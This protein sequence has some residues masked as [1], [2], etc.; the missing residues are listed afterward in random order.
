MKKVIFEEGVEELEKSAVR[1]FP[2]ITGSLIYSHIKEV[3]FP[4][5]VNKINKYAKQN[6]LDAE[7]KIMCGTNVLAS[8]MPKFRM[9]EAGI[10][11]IK[12]IKDVCLLGAGWREYEN[13]P[14][15]Y[16]KYFW[17]KV[18][19][20]ELIHSVRDSYTEEKLKKLGFENVV[21]TSCPTMWRLTPEHCGQI[22]TKKSNNVLTTLTD[23]R[24]NIKD[25]RTTII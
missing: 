25:D 21:N 8:R 6:C 3:Y 7:F 5:S 11:D 1:Q 13:E 23:Y 12:Y 4:R 19:N 18:L 22:P 2:H 15:C 16:T 24:R 14:N 10:R 17:E 9:W 20:K